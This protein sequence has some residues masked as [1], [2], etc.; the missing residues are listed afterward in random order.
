[1]SP[2]TQSLKISFKIWNNVASWASSISGRHLR[3]PPQKLVA[4]VTVIKVPLGN[5]IKQ[6]IVMTSDYA[7]CSMYMMWLLN[8]K[9]NCIKVMDT[10]F[11]FKIWRQSHYAHC[12]VF[13]PATWIVKNIQHLQPYSYHQTKRQ[14][15]LLY[16]SYW[17]WPCELPTFVHKS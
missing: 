16:P 1:M 4:T 15:E 14:I 9:L 12:C 6:Q 5:S 3:L 2:I 8:L 17:P 10:R 13:Q 11:L 7:S